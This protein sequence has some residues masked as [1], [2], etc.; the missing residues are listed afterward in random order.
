MTPGFCSSTSFTQMIAVGYSI[1]HSFPLPPTASLSPAF[2][3][4]DGQAGARQW[5][6]GESREPQFSA[7]EGEMSAS[8]CT[9]SL[10]ESGRDALWV[11]SQPPSPSPHSVQVLSVREAQSL[12][13]DEED[14]VIA[15]YDYWL[16]KRLRLGR[17][18]IPTVKHERRDGTSSSNPY[19][20]FRKRT[21]K[22]QTRKVSERSLLSVLHSTDLQN[23]Q[24]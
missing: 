23:I 18:L 4:D 22:M 5:Q 13:K 11:L 15:V 20:A 3:E 8:L 12:L 10:S 17:S 16:A 9:L 24:C 1:T 14:L 6:H 19:L 21:E 7:G 2:R